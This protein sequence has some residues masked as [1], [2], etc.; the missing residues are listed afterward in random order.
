MAFAVTKHIARVALTAL[1]LGAAANAQPA[2]D[3]VSVGLTLDAEP[4][5]LTFKMVQQPVISLTAADV[6]QSEDPTTQL[7]GVGCLTTSFEFLDITISSDHPFPALRSGFRDFLS[8]GT[9]E[10]YLLYT[11]TPSYLGEGIGL[12]GG[13]PNPDYTG[14]P[15]T[16]QFKNKTDG[17]NLVQGDED[18]TGIVYAGTTGG[19]DQGAYGPGNFFMNSYI[20]HERRTFSSAFWPDNAY[21]SLPGLLDD[22]DAG[23]MTFTDTVT[24]TFSPNLGS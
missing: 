10:H 7:F 13:G 16:W 20:H 6:Y 3:D 8:D 12:V 24:I 11:M 14:N 5:F 22:L 21:Y 17:Y 18:C 4:S 15:F 9:N 2:Q 23:T 1:A 19:R